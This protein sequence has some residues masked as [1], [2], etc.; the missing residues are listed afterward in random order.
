MGID[1]HFVSVE[2]IS[3]TMDILWTVNTISIMQA[4]TSATHVDMPEVKCL[5]QARIE[6][7]HLDRLEGVLIVEEL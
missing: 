6:V 7:N 4:G 3:M 1:Q 2:P 5:V